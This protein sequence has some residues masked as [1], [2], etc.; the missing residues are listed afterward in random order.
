MR[1]LADR[2]LNPTHIAS[3]FTCTAADIQVPQQTY[4]TYTEAHGDSCATC[5]DVRQGPL[6]L[7]GPPLGCNVGHCRHDGLHSAGSGASLLGRVLWPR[8]SRLQEFAH[9]GYEFA[10]G[11]AHSYMCNMVV[12]AN[13]GQC[14]ASRKHC[15]LDAQE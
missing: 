4:R 2:D 9:L 14:E 3:P 7:V 8:L 1:C 10:E 15:P 6:Q 5:N 12:H 11:P 13:D